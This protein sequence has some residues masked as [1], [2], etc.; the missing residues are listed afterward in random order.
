VKV[1]ATVEGD[2]L[3]ID[4][5]GSSPQN[6]G[7]V[8]CGLP[9]A[10]ASCRIA[11]KA[12]TSPGT[13]A[14]EGD[15]VPLHVTAPER[16]MYNAVYPAPTLLYAKGL[17]DVVV[18]A[19]TGAVPDRGIAGNYD[20]LAGFML[21]G[22]DPRTGAMYIQQARV[23]GGWGGCA[24]AD[25]ENALI[26]TGDGDTKNVPAEVVEG[27]FPLRVERHEL[28]RDSGGP[29][30]NR[31]GLGIVRDYRL[32]GHAA[33]MM[34]VMDR[35]VC[36][37]WGLDGGADAMPDDVL[38]VPNGKEAHYTRVNEEWVPAGALVSV[39]TGGGG[40]WGSPFEREPE[41]VRRDVVC[42]Y[43]SVEAAERDY[44]VVLDA[45]TCAVDAEASA[46]LRRVS[47]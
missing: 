4:L 19:L 11:L 34:C 26:F 27:R 5:T 17:I 9:A 32:L 47:M 2:E 46:A 15:F 31:G 44:G 36:P 40:G 30:R 28:R 38:V 21:V 6:V 23:F 1:K 13:P 22:T 20:D 18:K 3:T 35:T 25:G 10:I 41:R 7:P 42:G 24:R 33:R 14:N 43:V 16:C 37:P 45:A 39:R 8:N 12:F 29:G